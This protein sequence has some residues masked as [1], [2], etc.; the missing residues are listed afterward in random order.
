MSQ[1]G[2]SDCPV[3][4]QAQINRLMQ[5][6]KTRLARNLLGIYFHGSLATNCF[7]PLRSDLDLLVVTRLGMSL[8]TKREIAESLLENSRRPSPIEISFLRREDLSPW[9]H[10]TPFDFHYSEDWR[11][12]FERD[13]ADGNWETWNDVQ[14]CDDDL[15]AHIT[16]TNHRGLCLYGLPK[17][18]VFPNVPEQDFAAS[19]LGDIQ[20][21]NFGLN[22]IL[23]FPVYVVLN[24]C[25]TFAYLQTG[26]V[27]SKEEGGVWGLQNF[28][29][30][31]HDVIKGALTEYRECGNE[32]ALEKEQLIEFA[33]FMRREIERALIK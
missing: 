15:A 11:A 1:Y 7:N 17:A 6:L 5:E 29:G 13:L 8:E 2:L 22:V 18:D 16:V 25:R 26:R 28:P 30:Q 3:K 23:Q 21:A 4:V 10:P 14:H 9:R 19:I 12:R 20:S 24:V 33:T 32:S 27:M 31:F